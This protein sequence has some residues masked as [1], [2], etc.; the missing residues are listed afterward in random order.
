MWSL[1][2]LTENFVVK[3]NREDELKFFLI[4]IPSPERA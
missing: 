3:T 2:D 1:Y 4:I